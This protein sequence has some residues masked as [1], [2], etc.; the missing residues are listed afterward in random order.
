MADVIEP[1]SRER[2]EAELHANLCFIARALRRIEAGENLE[3][4]LR[5]LRTSI[6]TCL[7]GVSPNEC[8]ARAAD[9]LYRSA[10][11]L[12]Y[13]QEREI[14]LDEEPHVSP[15][16]LEAAEAALARFQ[17]VLLNADPVLNSSTQ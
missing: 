14:L 16:R 5:N 17:A 2:Q 4:E 6:L 1:K 15:T 11:E 10:Y 9:K 7:E 3:P 8:L 12:A 13:E